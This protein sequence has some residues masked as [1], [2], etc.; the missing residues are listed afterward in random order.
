MP[1][2]FVNCLLQG[3]FK[4]AGTEALRFTINSTMGIGGFFDPAKSQFHLKVQDEDFGQTLGKYKMG[5]VLFI[6][7]PFLGPSTLRDT[8]GYVG[9]TAL[10]PLTILSFYI[11]PFVTEGAYTYNVFNEISID[12]GESYENITKPAI[13]PYIALQDSYIQN[14]TKR[15]KE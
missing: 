13:D 4:G 14:R 6:Q 8:L 10:D 2:R 9:D 3:K 5:Q 12:K 1:D 15:I 11:N 7:W